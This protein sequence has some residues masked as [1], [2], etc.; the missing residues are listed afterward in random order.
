[1]AAVSYAMYSLSKVDKKNVEQSSALFAFKGEDY[2]EFTHSFKTGK[3]FIR[4]TKGNTVDP[5][6][7]FSDDIVIIVANDEIFGKFGGNTLLRHGC[8]DISISFKLDNMFM[9][10]EHI[11]SLGECVYS[12][13]LMYESAET[14]QRRNK[15]AIRHSQNFMFVLESGAAVKQ[16]PLLISIHYELN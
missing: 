6:Q 4:K 2:N 12:Q 9:S 7:P 3:L 15:F 14:V 1:M 11:Q 8:R 16:V 10:S 13:F 5:K